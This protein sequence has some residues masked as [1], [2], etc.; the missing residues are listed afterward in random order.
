L[1]FSNRY[2][3]EMGFPA[4]GKK[5]GGFEVDSVS[6]E[7]IAKYDENLARYEYP[8][9]IL[10]QGEGTVDDVAKAFYRLFST[11]RQ[12]LSSYG[13]PYQCEPGELEVRDLGGGRFMIAARGSCVRL[14]QSS[15]RQGETVDLREVSL[16]A[17]KAMFGGRDSVEVEGLKYLIERTPRTRLRLVRIGEHTF[18]E[19]NPD[20]SS[21][22]AKMAREGHFIMWVL[23]GRRYL[24]QVRDG[25]FHDFRKKS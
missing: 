8:T 7:H 10:V 24:A 5:V 3:R 20:K 19:Q 15:G 14:H 1:P 4:K 16:E 13:N 9:E 21:R 2:R 22:W 25:E 6:I 11:R 18:L 12:I 23:Q 17:Y